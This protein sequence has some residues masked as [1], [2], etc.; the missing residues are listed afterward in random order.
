M[1]EVDKDGKNIKDKISHKIVGEVL[2]L[3]HSTAKDLYFFPML[4]EAA[5]G[6]G[7]ANLGLPMGNVNLSASMKAVTQAEDN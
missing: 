4:P 6:A 1:P 7:I 2:M 3:E 5:K